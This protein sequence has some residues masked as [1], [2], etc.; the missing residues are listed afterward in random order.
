MECNLYS[1]EVTIK[2]RLTKH[3]IL[4][5]PDKFLLRKGGF[6]NGIETKRSWKL[7]SSDIVAKENTINYKGL[8][9]TKSGKYEHPYSDAAR[10][11]FEVSRD[12]KLGATSRIELE[13]IPQSN[14]SKFSSLWKG[15]YER[16]GVHPAY[17]D[18]AISPNFSDK[19]YFIS[20]CCL[21]KNSLAVD[22]NNKT[23]EIDKDIISPIN[24][25]YSEDTCVCSE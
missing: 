4:E 12:F 11:D 10:R 24:R 8:V 15:I 2:G 14:I 18:V 3:E 9:F 6:T 13:G 17:L 21:Q 19:T 20:W 5:C 25:S 22:D 23:Y 7:I 1:A 16:C